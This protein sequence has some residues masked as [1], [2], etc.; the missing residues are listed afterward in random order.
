M[1][2]NLIIAALLLLILAAVKHKQEK[3]AEPG[4]Y[5]YAQSPMQ[6]FSLVTQEIQNG[7]CDEQYQAFIADPTN[8][9]KESALMQ[10]KGQQ[11]LL[12]G[13]IAGLFSGGSG[14]TG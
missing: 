3:F 9:E 4:G 5:T 6:Q 8:V 13:K 10:C 12:V 14:R 1:L 7:F 11:N 2:A